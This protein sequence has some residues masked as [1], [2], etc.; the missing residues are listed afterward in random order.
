MKKISLIVI[1]CLA[2]ALAPMQAENKKQN[3]IQRA[4]EAFERWKE[5]VHPTPEAEPN[6]EIPQYMLQDF[7]GTPLFLNTNTITA[8]EVGTPTQNES[9]IAVNPKNPK[10]IIA[11]AVDYRAEGSTWIYVSTDGGHTWDNQNLGKVKGLWSS[12]NDPSVS[13]NADGVA[14]LMYGAF[15][16]T[17]NGMNGVFMARSSNEGKTWE[18]HIPVIIHDTPQ[19]LDSSFEDKYYIQVDNASKSPYFKNLYTPWKRVI[20]RD[21]STQIVFTR[22]TDGGTVWSKPIPISPKKTGTSED[23]TYG[24]S[25]PLLTTGPKG[26]IYAVWNDGIEHS[27]GFNSSMDGGL[28]WSQPKFIQKYNIFGETKYLASQQGYRHSLKGFVRAEAYP[29][30]ACDYTDGKYSGN[31]YVIWTADNTPNVYFSKSTNKGD[32]WTAPKMVHSEIKNDQFWAWLAIDPTNGDLGVMYLDSRNDPNNLLVECYASFSQ[33]GGDTWIDRRVSDVVSDIRNN[34]FNGSF[35]GDYSGLA[36]YNGRMYPSWVDMRNTTQANKSDNDVYTA[37][38][39]VNGPRPPDPFTAESDVANVQDVNLKWTPI[40]ESTFGKTLVPADIQYQLYR[41]SELLGTLISTVTNFADK[42]L[43]LYKQ[44]EY[45]I[46][47]ITKDDSSTFAKVKVFPG[48]A[49]E[50]KAPEFSGILI[51]KGEFKV[52][53]PD[54]KIDNTTQIV[55]LKKLL[56]YYDRSKSVSEEIILNDSQIGKEIAI[57]PKNLGNREGFYTV[58]GRVIT[59][60][61]NSP[62]DSGLFG[63]EHIVFKGKV[64]GDNQRYLRENFDNKDSIYKFYMS[65]NWKTTQRAAHSKNNSLTN[66]G[67]SE[68]N[69]RQTDTLILP[70]FTN[71]DLLL[72]DSKDNSI[73]SGPVKSISYWHIANLEKKDT[74]FL[75]YSGDMINW[76]N[77][78]KYNELDYA[79]WQDKVLEESD[80]VYEKIDLYALQNLQEMETFLRFRFWA[81]PLRTSLGWFIDDIE[82]ERYLSDIESEEKAEP[83]AIYPNP[84]SDVLYLGNK[85]NVVIRKIELI[86]LLGISLF[87][88]NEADISQTTKLDTRNLATG[89]YILKVTDS[90]GRTAIQQVEVVR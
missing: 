9:S 67:V 14:Y 68:Y 74:A 66:S 76:T 33:D 32:S 18:A 5:M 89:R 78:K 85:S 2:I 82:I 60:Y 69:N 53:L 51:N 58:N 73:Q 77:I 62:A 15:T 13:F 49:K 63:L 79:G 80:W 23:T 87:E 46:R 6:N 55:G 20:N 43:T 22:S 10:N 44:Y 39:N 81:D 36:F 56:L 47:A 30:V 40:F 16:S 45:K 48:G 84:T 29:V 1:L 72:Q 4:K 11:S 31:L 7:N 38:V 83:M 57:T 50:A 86:S 28:T 35:A 3:E 42:G 59:Q 90:K 21:S 88:L 8:N 19:T 24:Q 17:S 12:S 52:S 37:I 27:V 34:P 64:L 54:Y 26:E 75:E 25:F 71:M 41:D 70:P 61:N 65:A